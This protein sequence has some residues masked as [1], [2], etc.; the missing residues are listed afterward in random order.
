MSEFL[1]SHSIVSSSMLLNLR[2]RS[3]FDGEFDDVQTKR[4]SRVGLKGVS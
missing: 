4:K 3:N 2:L 1:E